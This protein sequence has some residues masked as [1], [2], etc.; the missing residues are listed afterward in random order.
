[1]LLCPTLSVGDVAQTLFRPLQ[2]DAHFGR[3]VLVASTKLGDL[4]IFT[5]EGYLSDFMLALATRRAVSVVT[6][7]SAWSAPEGL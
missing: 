4:I 6:E 3:L 2:V 7:G 5:Q 1:M